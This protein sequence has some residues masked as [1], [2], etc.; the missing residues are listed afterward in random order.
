[1]S[2]LKGRKNFQSIRCVSS[3]AR[4]FSELVSSSLSKRK[5]LAWESRLCPVGNENYLIFGFDFVRGEKRKGAAFL[6]PHMTTHTGSTSPLYP[7]GV[8]TGPLHRSGNWGSQVRIHNEISQIQSRELTK[9]AQGHAHASRC[10]EADSS[11]KKQKN[12]NN[13]TLYFPLTPASQPFLHFSRILEM[14]GS[15]EVSSDMERYKPPTSPCCYP[16][17]KLILILNHRERLNA[18]CVKQ[19][20]WELKRVQTHNKKACCW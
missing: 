4:R 7:L 17:R 13:L 10:Q 18:K 12:T 11:S 2:W 3:R 20:I 19:L 1:M 15:P 14:W 9:Q 5:V 8:D 16:L 6:T